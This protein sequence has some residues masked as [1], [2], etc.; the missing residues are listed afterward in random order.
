MGPSIRSLK[1]I[2]ISKNNNSY[3]K[4]F[5]FFKIKFEMSHIL[6]TFKRFIVNQ[7][8]KRG[9]KA[10]AIKSTATTILILFK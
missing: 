8:K 4:I 5:L 10:G 2:S 7:K 3:C 9:F 6:Q 1:T